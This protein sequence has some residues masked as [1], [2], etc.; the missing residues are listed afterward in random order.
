MNDKLIK[1]IW[2]TYYTNPNISFRQELYLPTR[3]PRR[4]HKNRRVQKK[5]IKRFGEI[6][7]Y[8]IKQI[9]LQDSINQYARVIVV[10]YVNSP[11]KNV[12]HVAIESDLKYTVSNPN[13]KIVYQTKHYE[14]ESIG[15]QISLSIDAYYHLK[16]NN[17][18]E[19]SLMERFNR[20]SMAYLKNIKEND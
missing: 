8:E 14:L 12:H 16:E 19:K 18:L 4:F 15:C 7:T 3:V 5:W 17:I 13:D 2:N 9:P 11:T 6:T 1:Q 10:L 20:E